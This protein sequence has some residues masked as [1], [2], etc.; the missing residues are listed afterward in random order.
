MEYLSVSLDLFPKAYSVERS[1]YVWLAAVVSK[2][3][4]GRFLPGEKTRTDGTRGEVATPVCRTW[5]VPPLAAD[6]QPVA[7]SVD[8]EALSGGK[9]GHY[10][11]QH[12]TPL[13]C[14]PEGTLRCELWSNRGVIGGSGCL[15]ED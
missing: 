14:S 2:R 7:G 9:G 1:S 5:S 10:G 12:A 3:I 8:S 4:S 11:R 6:R 13:G 15:G